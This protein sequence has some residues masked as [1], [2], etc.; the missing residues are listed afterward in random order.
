[1]GPRHLLKKRKAGRLMAPTFHYLSFNASPTQSFLL[2]WA[3]K[4]RS[5]CGARGDILVL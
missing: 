3:G 4:V 1:M 5:C 2:T